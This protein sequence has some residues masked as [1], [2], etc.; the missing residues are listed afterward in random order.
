M[1]KVISFR[2]SVC[3]AGLR[4]LYKITNLTIAIV[5]RECYS[6]WLDPNKVGT[7]EDA[8]DDELRETFGVTNADV[9]FTD[10]SLGGL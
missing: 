7:Y 10:R 3:S 2:C 6:I 8:D 5:C 1:A 9:F 4:Y